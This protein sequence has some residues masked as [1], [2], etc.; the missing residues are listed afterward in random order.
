MQFPGQAKPPAGIIFDSAMSRI[1]DALA[2]ALL[3][4]FDG[5]NEARV[6]SVSVSRP[7]LRAAAFCDAV[8]R[9]YAGSVSGAF[10]GFGRTLPIGLAGGGKEAEDVPMLSAPLARQD[11]QGKAVYEH[12]IRTINDTAE[13]A[14]LMR[15]ALTAQYDQNAIVVLTGPA[16]NLVKV[17]DLPG[18]K[19]L[20]SRKVRFLSVVAGA[21]PDGPPEVNVR[22]DIPAARKLLAEWP[23]PIVAAG[24]EVGEALPFP[25]VSIEKDFAWSTAHPVVDAYRAYR[26]MPYEASTWALAAVL[27]AVRPQEGYFKLS[28]PGTIGVLGDGRSRFVASPEGKHRYLMVDPAQKDRII[29]TYTEVASAKPVPRQ[30]RIRRKQQDQQQKADTVPVAKP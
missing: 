28:G 14:A 1:D 10:G 21:Y 18:V 22:A 16:T 8:G 26:A 19:D 2:L 5:K 20:I 4:G 30:P 23:T 7:D 29:K 6:I 17:L 9:F 27:Y 25:G 13:V 3:Y 24:Y 12:E 11:A 15:N